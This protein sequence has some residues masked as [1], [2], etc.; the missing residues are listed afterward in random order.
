MNKNLY[1]AAAPERISAIAAERGLFE[2]LGVRPLVG[3]TFLPDDP[4]NVAVVS[5]G[6]WRGR[7]GGLGR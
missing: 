6:F 2:L 4:P 7:Y 1:D 3:R 5:E